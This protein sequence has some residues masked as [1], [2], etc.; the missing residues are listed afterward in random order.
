MGSQAACGKV[1]K[2]GNANFGPALSK[3]CRFSP[4][5][6]LLRDS[7]DNVPVRHIIGELR[8]YRDHAC[9]ARLNSQMPANSGN[10]VL[11]DERR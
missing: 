11:A 6:D 9:R 1:Q 8:G 4:S 10:F 3:V 7:W 2:S 5:N